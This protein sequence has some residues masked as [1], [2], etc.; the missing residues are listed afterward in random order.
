MDKTSN[1]ELN[2]I[3]EILG[4]AISGDIY[5][6]VDCL[7]NKYD[8][9]VDG[10]IKHFEKLEKE[11]KLYKKAFNLACDVLTDTLD[12]KRNCEEDLYYKCVS[13]KEKFC[14]HSSPEKM[15]KY[16]LNKAQEKE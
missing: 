15:E 12:C 6:N 9:T 14:F 1:K 10:A 7:E 11:L 3:K 2:L 13:S 4:I 5:N 8:I 16:F